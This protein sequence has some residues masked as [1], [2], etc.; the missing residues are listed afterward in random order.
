MQA[1]QRGNRCSDEDRAEKLLNVVKSVIQADSGKFEAFL[2][3][4]THHVPAMAEKL[5]VHVP[6]GY[7]K[8]LSMLC[9][10]TAPERQ[11]Q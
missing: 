6:Y 10:P 1:E 7:G 8:H 5:H 2:E 4:L 11:C 9:Q 3:I